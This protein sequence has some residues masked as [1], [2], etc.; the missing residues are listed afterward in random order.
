MDKFTIAILI[1]AGM[2]AVLFS[3]N[4]QQHYSL[5]PSYVRLW[6]EECQEEILKLKH[7]LSLVPKLPAEIAKLKEEVKRLKAQKETLK[8][9]PTETDLQKKLKELQDRRR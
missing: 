6:R 5:D 4:R 3:N 2:F 8:I 9:L 7:R 1:F